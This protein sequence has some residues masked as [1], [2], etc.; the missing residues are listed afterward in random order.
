MSLPLQT[1]CN[2]ITT[3]GLDEAVIKMSRMCSF[4]EKADVGCPVGGSFGG[5][6][7]RS[8]EPTS[9]VWNTKL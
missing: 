3:A 7:A 1:T 4:V 2:N 8:L 9:M 5:G 6:F